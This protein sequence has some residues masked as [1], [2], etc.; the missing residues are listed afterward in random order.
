MAAILAGTFGLN[1]ELKC[2]PARSDDRRLAVG[3]SYAL[4]ADEDATTVTLTSLRRHHGRWLIALAGITTQEAARPFVG[5][6]LFIEASSLELA[7][8]E[9][10]DADL[11]GLR[12]VDEAGS[13]LGTVAR[14]QHY[15]AQDCIVVAEGGGLIPMVRAF[16]KR[17]DL[18]G[19]TI[20]VSLPP[21]L[22]DSSAAEEA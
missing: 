14:M 13:Q 5:R 22:L 19:G 15:P 12:I 6:E 7:E 2:V 9:Y 10:L 21:G 20:V 3:R 16:V 18:V 17:V 1:G 11:V 8:N 4:S